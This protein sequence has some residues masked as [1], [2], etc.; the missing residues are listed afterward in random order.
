MGEVNG[1]KF[2]TVEYRL[3][4]GTDFTA[5]IEK[6]TA[7]IC[8]KVC[9]L[10]ELQFLSA[11]RT[12]TVVLPHLFTTTRTA[13]VPWLLLCLVNN[14]SGDNAS[15]DGNDGITQQHNKCGQQTSDRGYRCD[16]AIAYG[17]Q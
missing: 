16:V 13:S 11:V 15:G 12:V 3:N 17:G 9:R 1:L 6:D 5:F 10:C 4:S 2:Q 8:G 14:G 7:I